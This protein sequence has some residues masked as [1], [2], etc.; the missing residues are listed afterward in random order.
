MHSQ[1]KALVEVLSSRDKQS[2]TDLIAD[3]FCTE[4]E[5]GFSDIES[6]SESDQEEALCKLY[7]VI[8]NNVVISTKV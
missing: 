1:Y 2:M 4:P 6:D 7:P 5:V 8:V 3:Y